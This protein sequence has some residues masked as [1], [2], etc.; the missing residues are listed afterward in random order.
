MLEPVWSPYIVNEIYLV[1]LLLKLG[2]AGFT[3][4]C[5]TAEHQVANNPGIKH[6]FTLMK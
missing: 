2:A 1:A 3:E 4:E 5:S 6:A